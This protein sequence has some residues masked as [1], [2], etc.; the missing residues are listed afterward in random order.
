MAWAL[1]R[2]AAQ[3]A[4]RRCI[5]AEQPAQSLAQGALGID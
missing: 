1:W 2:L 5:D 4:S 3:A